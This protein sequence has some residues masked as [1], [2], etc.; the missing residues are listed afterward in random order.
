MKPRSKGVRIFLLILILCFITGSAFLY[1]RAGG[2]GGGRSGGSSGGGGGGG[3]I[4]FYIIM[5]LVNTIGPIPTAIV[6]IVAI[7][8]LSI[9]GK[10]MKSSSP[11]KN[12]KPLSRPVEN[13][14]GYNQFISS[15]PG[16]SEEIFKQ[17]VTAAF[18]AIQEAWTRQDLK[19]VRRFISDGVYQRFSTQFTMMKLLTLVSP[20]TPMLMGFMTSSFRELSMNEAELAA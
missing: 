6:V 19:S 3:A 18:L 8:L 11:M 1:A 7:V 15:N 16:F 14:K 10:K 9:F 13:L 4:I 17:K 20:L 2:A 12:L 5:M